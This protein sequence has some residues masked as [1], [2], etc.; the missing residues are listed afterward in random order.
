MVLTGPS[1]SDRLRMN[2]TEE[3]QSRTAA[4]PMAVARVEWRGVIG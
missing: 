4:K 1:L 2:A 3:L